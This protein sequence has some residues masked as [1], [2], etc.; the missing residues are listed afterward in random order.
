MTLRAYWVTWPVLG[1]R[2]PVVKSVING[3]TEVEFWMAV[4][5]KMGL[6]D[7]KGYS[8]GDLSYDAFM[9][10]NTSQRPI[11]KNRTGRHTR[12]TTLAMTGKT[13]YEKFK[14]K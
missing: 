4:M 10:T 13:E 8:P 7:Q 14:K 2:K 5:K 1:L 12:K 6:R 3:M 9:L 11:S